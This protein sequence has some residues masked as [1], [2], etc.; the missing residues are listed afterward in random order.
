MTMHEA[1]QSKAAADA[2][3]AVLSGACVTPALLE[4]GLDAGLA[5]WQFAD[6]D[7]GRIFSAILAM[8]EARDPIS[9]DAL[10][11]ICTGTVSDK[12]LET[13][14]RGIER[15]PGSR[16]LFD[17][18]LARLQLEASKRKVNASLR[19]MIAEASE[20]DDMAS[21]QA[22]IISLSEQASSVIT[23]HG[24]M[25]RGAAE[26]AADL[27]VKVTTPHRRVPTGIRKL[28]HVLGGGLEKGKMIALIGRYKI[29]KTTLLSTVGYNI[30]QPE[31]DPEQG[32]KVLFVTLERSE[33]DIEMLNAARS[34]KIN[35]RELENSFIRHR[36]SFEEYQQHPDRSR[37]FYHHSP[38]ATIEEVVQV[39][40]NAVRTE[41][42]EVALI[43]Y[44]QVIIA[45]KHTRTVDHLSNVDRTLSRLAASLDIAIVLA[46]QADADGLP[47][48]CKALLHSAAANFSIRRAPDQ[49][50]TWLE[51][52]ASNYIEQRDAGNPRDPALRLVTTSG[53]YFESI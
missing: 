27:Q 10:A 37:V 22:A 8:R 53:P 29:G 15:W 40:T 7:D 20:A 44:Y 35:Q 1:V 42:I 23:P 43:D 45:P 50:D 14:L 47:R 21:L 30:S 5:A 39:V 16:V 13:L 24:P 32:R 49:P 12:R 51:N 19:A 52:L 34:L 26:V 25:P 6:P 9:G 36:R 17:K 38:G 46:A 18:S 4:V 31:P 41:G 48:D 33:T 3:I 11:G 2:A 28:D